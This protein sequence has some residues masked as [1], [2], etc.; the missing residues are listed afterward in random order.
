MFKIPVLQTL[1]N[2]SDDRATFVIQDRLSFMRLLG[3]GLSHKV[4][5]AKTIW[6]FRGSLVRAGAINNLFARF[7][8]HRDDHPGSQ[9]AQQPGREES[10]QSR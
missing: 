9:A 4:Q 10:D 5:D 7:G 1:Y 6:L 2:L 8:K 3:L